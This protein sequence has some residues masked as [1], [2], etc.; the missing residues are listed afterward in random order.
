MEKDAREE[1]TNCRT[2]KAHTQLLDQESE[3]KSIAK[4]LETH[5][6]IAFDTE[7]IREKTFFPNVEILQIATA[8]EAWL[9]DARLGKKILEPL[10]KVLTNPHILKIAHAAQGDQECFFTAFG[11]VARP[12]LDTSV[13]AGLCGYGESIG[14]GNLLKDLL[15]I[16]L[17]KGHARTNW[18]VRPL[19]AELVEYALS[20]VL[21]LVKV[22]QV[23]LS[24]LEKNGR[25][26]WALKLSSQ[27]EDIKIYEPSAETLARR[28]S[29]SGRVDR[30]TYAALVELMDWREKRVREL[31]LPRRWVAD[32]QV[33]LDLAK[34]R[35]KDLD[36]L[37]AF[38]GLNKGEIKK[39]GETI[40]AALKRAAERTDLIPPR[41]E[42]SVNP[43]AAESQVMDLLRCYVGML[44]FQQKVAM[45]YVLSS[46][47]LLSLIRLAPQSLDELVQHQLLGPEA[48][49][50]IGNEVIAFLQGKRALSVRGSTVEVVKINV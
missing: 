31:N 48:A 12:L 5:D 2:M 42:K 37:S 21:H 49:D 9:V 18:S 20:D 25:K 15:D 43:T 47:E 19:P 22:G 16:E 10:L 29:R 27:W 24:E 40:L 44:C 50:L 46:A 4:V 35:P 11:I 6:T 26:A 17:K 8:S 32:D 41:L 14:L 33:L 13:A 7:F 28:F 38:R 30:R 34:V 23:L 39:S 1:R 36:H 3:I 45:R